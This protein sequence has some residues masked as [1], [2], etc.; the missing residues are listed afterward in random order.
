MPTMQLFDNCSYYVFENSK[1]VAPD[2]HAPPC[3]NILKH[4]EE[5]SERITQIA[6][7]TTGIN[8]VLP[9]HIISS[10]MDIFIREASNI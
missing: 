7:E 2:K 8:Q 1:G 6:I 4:L 9:L 5:W 10:E 3:E